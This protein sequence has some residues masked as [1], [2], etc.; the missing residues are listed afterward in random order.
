[1]IIVVSVVQRLR[2]WSS[3]DRRTL[4]T[5]LGIGA[6]KRAMLAIEV[7]VTQQSP[8]FSIFGLIAFGLFAVTAMLVCY[9]LEETQ[10]VVHSGVCG[11]LRPRFSLRISPRRVAIRS[12]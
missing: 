7:N 9:A 6:V 8:Q 12:D 2:R 5:Q 1:M 3:A 10:H 4:P 11:L